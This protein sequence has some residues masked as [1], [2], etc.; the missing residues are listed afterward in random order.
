MAKLTIKHL[1]EKSLK[2]E[3]LGSIDSLPDYTVDPFYEKP[4]KDILTTLQTIKY[5][6]NNLTLC[7]FSHNN[8]SE[9][10]VEI[11]CNDIEEFKKFLE[12][13]SQ[14]IPQKEPIFFKNI[15]VKNLSESLY[16]EPKIKKK[17][18]YNKDRHF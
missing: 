6:L 16:K 12:F 1:I 18:Y 4:W 7:L 2:S 14:S 8:K 11:I 13:F 10:V 5:N 9:Y 17:P 15:H 3:T